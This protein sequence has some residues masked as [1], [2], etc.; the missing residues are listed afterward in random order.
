M[1]VKFLVIFSFVASV[2]GDLSGER[3]TSEFEHPEGSVYVKP[4]DIN[5][6]CARFYISD[7][8]KEEKG[9]KYWQ[10]S[11]RQACENK[12]FQISSITH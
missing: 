1:F 11:I 2:H 6:G 12:M 4:A 9:T 3:G 10:V 8:I 5:P 7:P